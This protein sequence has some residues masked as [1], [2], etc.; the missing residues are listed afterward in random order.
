MEKLLIK[1]FK[2]EL[3]RSLYPAD[4]MGGHLLRVGVVILPAFGALVLF[5][6]LPVVSLAEESSNGKGRHARPAGR[7][8]PS[9][10]RGNA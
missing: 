9:R 6:V 8:P 4:W 10:G 3:D 2:A 5:L 1:D 7:P